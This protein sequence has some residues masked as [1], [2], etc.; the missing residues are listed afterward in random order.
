MLVWRTSRDLRQKPASLQIAVVW[1]VLLSIAV[2]LAGCS[3]SP[4]RTPRM[5]KAWSKGL[6]LGLASL[7]NQVALDVDPEGRVV[8][9]WVGMDQDIRLVRL[10]GRA[11]VEVDRPLDLTL[12][13]P[14]GVRIGVDADGQVHLV[15]LDRVDRVLQVLYARF[16]PEGDVLQP[17]TQLSAAGLQSGR[18]AV[19]VDPEAR[20]FEV[21]WSDAF[22]SHPGIYH[23]ALSWAGS[24][25]VPAELLI[26]EGLAPSVATDRQGYIHLA[27]REEAENQPVA[28]HYAIYD[29]QRRLLGPSAQVAEPVAEASMMG[30]PAAGAKFHGPQLGL[31]RD[32]VYLA[33]MLEV[34]QRGNLTALTFFQVFPQP[35]L[36]SVDRSGRF[37]YEPPEVASN[38]V[39]VRG[40]DPSLT[41]DPALVGGHPEEQVLA[42]Y[43]MAEG[44]RNLEML[45]SAV[46][47]LSDP[48]LGM[49]IVSATTGASL[50]A[51]IAVDG[52]QNLHL[53]WIDTAGFD[54]YKVLYASTAPQVQEVLNPVTVGEVL[55]Q[56]LELGFGA[57]TLIGFLPLYLLWAV[58]G[59]LTL[60]LFWTVT[61]GVDLSQ[62]QGRVALACGIGVHGLVKLATAGGALNRLSTGGLLTAAWQET[63]IRWAVPLLITALS[64][65]I[66]RV[67]VR[68][69]GTVSLFGA[70]FIFV[71]IDAL[72]FTLIYLTPLLLWG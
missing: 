2:L 52:Q 60:F 25:V 69:T 44:P 70:F 42:C 63:V 28:F 12:N 22:A 13:H 35:A 49:D 10:N 47:H 53:V 15:W 37:S 68:R 4:I 45:Q 36:E 65:W 17:A 30:G 38:P 58:P 19:T 21:F 51:S 55:S 9:A 56:V 24:P 6:P 29:P 50:K 40:G 31:S 32:S 33:W 7:N 8:A 41:G 27:W 46:V 16:S 1:T 57:L 59:L 67:Y 20:T 34:R 71:L 43:T 11:G 66:T 48:Q 23:A 54:R 39:Q 62:P 14:Q 72:L 3:T 61:Q 18:V 26:A 5:S 64:A